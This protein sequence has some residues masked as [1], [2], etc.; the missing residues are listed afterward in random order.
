MTESTDLDL[1]AVRRLVEAAV[2][3]RF[4]LAPGDRVLAEEGSLAVV[5]TPLAE[6]Y[7]TATLAEARIDDA[8][9]PL[10]GGRW[11]RPA[12]TGRRVTR[13]RRPA[14]TAAEGELLFA[15]RGSW[16]VASGDHPEPLD[17]PVAGLIRE[18]RPGV[19]LVVRS[20]G[21]A[22]RGVRVIGGPARGRLELAGG[23]GGEL[24]PGALDVGSAGTILVVGTRVDAETLTRARAMGVRGVV[25]AGLPGKDERDYLA[26]E[27]RQRSAL[28]RLPPFAVL[29][30]DGALRRP[31]AGTVMGL[32]EALAGRDVAIVGDPPALVFDEPDLAI[33]LPPADLVRLRSGA[34]AGREG[35]WLGALGPRRFSG[36]IHLEAARVL[37]PDGPRV[38][39]LGDLERFV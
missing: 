9:E 1:V 24:R 15:W 29:V 21:R 3:V 39:P 23:P 10:P 33:A 8:S 28:H 11:V 25:V 38:V 36:G 30:L 31:I 17:A 19:G 6:R 35:R 32:F 13:G 16:R 34:D 14:R 4:D 7:R 12:E 20:T 37:F 5:G 22:V 18:V 2:D 26:S 27:A